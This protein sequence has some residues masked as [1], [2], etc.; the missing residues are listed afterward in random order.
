MFGGGPGALFGLMLPIMGVVAY[1]AWQAE[2]RRKAIWQSLATQFG[3]QYAA[4]DEMNVEG[5]AF[6]LFDRGHSRK[7]QCQIFGA[8]T[9][10]FEQGVRIAS[11]YQYTTG[12]GDNKQTKYF[13]CVMVNTPGHVPRVSIG[14]ESIGT[15]LLGVVGIDDIEL[16]STEF[17]ER[18]RVTSNEQKAA[19][20]I[21]DGKMQEWL[22]AESGEG[23]DNIELVG[24]KMLLTCNGK[25]VEKISGL[26]TLAHEFRERIPTVVASLYGAPIP[27]EKQP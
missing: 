2:Q 23:W 27:L 18:F 10:P 26:F 9:S 16:E 11:Q 8:D 7:V 24:S 4:Q 17:N 12:S 25:D 20:A 5:S 22:L 15:R 19:F 6:S 1:F 14:R 21:L 13:I 3:M